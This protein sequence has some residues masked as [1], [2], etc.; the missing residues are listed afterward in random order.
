MADENEVVGDD[1]VEIPHTKKDTWPQNVESHFIT[2]MEEEVKKG[3][4]QTTTLTRSAWQHI[5]KEMKKNLASNTQSSTRLWYNS[6]TTQIIATEDEWKKLCEFKKKCCLHYDKLSIIFGDTIASSANQHPST[7]SPSISDDGEEHDDDQEE[8]SSQSK[9]KVPISVDMKKRK[10]RENF[11]MAFAKALTVMS[12]TSKK[13]V[14]I[15]EKINTRI[16]VAPFTKAAKALKDD[17]TRR[18]VFLAISDER[19]KDLD[20][21]EAIDS[22]HISTCIPKDEQN[23]SINVLCC[24]SFDMKFT[25][26]MV[27]WEDMAND[28]RIF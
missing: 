2:L 14:D 15:L 20:C 4:R 23:P 11:Q 5:K 25:F 24:C 27:G 8:H 13:K 16:G 10:S 9:K 17:H 18:D 19:Q 22:T 21:V 3:I 1:V 6:T 28:L 7:K 12:E 26:V